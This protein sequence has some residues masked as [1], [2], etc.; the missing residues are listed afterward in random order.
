MWGA[1]GAL[2]SDCV[3]SCF[4]LTASLPDEGLGQAT[5]D[6]NARGVVRNF[7]RSFG[8]GFATALDRRQ[9]IWPTSR[10]PFMA[11]R[12]RANSPSSRSRFRRSPAA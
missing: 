7:I 9:I 1:I 11:T 5:P 10:S 12:D 4:P 6:F 8:D 2:A 3:G